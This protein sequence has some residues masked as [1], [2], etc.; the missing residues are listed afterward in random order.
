MG[1]AIA[2]VL[3][4]LALAALIRLGRAPR[5]AWE[6]VAAALVFGLAGFAFQAHPDQA[7]A[8]KA[9]AE[10]TGASGAAMV[11]ER[12]QMN[13]TGGPTSGDRWMIPADGAN[14]QRYFA[15]LMVTVPRI[16]NLVIVLVGCACM[17]GCA[18]FDSFAHATQY[19]CHPAWHGA[20]IVLRLAVCNVPVQRG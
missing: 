6:A 8:P 19:P 17:D 18:G 5:A 12:R 4:V 20:L 1:W 3:A 10:D 9:A 11:A 7:G 2:I 14:C 15:A 13:T 16:Q